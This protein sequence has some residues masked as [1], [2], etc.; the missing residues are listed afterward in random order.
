LRNNEGA[1]LSSVAFRNLQKLIDMAL[2]LK[3]KLGNYLIKKKIGIQ[4]Y[5]WIGKRLV[6]RFIVFG[7]FL[8][9]GSIIE[10]IILVPHILA[11]TAVEGSFW[12]LTIFTITIAIIFFIKGMNWRKKRLLLQ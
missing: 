4:G 6:S 7:I 5:F 8:L 1:K 10:I 2:V 3:D 9:I 11:N 12:L